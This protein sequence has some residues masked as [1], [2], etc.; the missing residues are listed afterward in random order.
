[1]AKKLFFE[2]TEI[3]KF[4][5]L[6]TQILSQRSVLYPI[7]KLRSSALICRIAR[8]SRLN[9]TRDTALQTLTLIF[10]VNLKNQVPARGKFEIV[11]H[12]QKIYIE[13]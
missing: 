3:Y 6:A 8:L 10:L 13:L 12:Q 9:S 5:I 2:K 4:E 1:M 7:G 11:V